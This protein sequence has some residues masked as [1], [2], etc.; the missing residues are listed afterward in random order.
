MV[1]SGWEGTLALS[2]ALP[3]QWGHVR[4]LS[5]H[6]VY[7]P[8][9]C[10]LV[11]QSSCMCREIPAPTELSYGETPASPE[12]MQ[13][14]HPSRC[15]VCPT[16]VPSA[17]DVMPAG[18]GNPA[19]LL[20]SPPSLAGALG[21]PHTEPTPDA[22]PL[23]RGVAGTEGYLSLPVPGCWPIDGGGVSRLGT[24]PGSSVPAD[25][26]GDLG[27]PGSTLPAAG[28]PLGPAPPACSSPGH[29]KE[30]LWERVSGFYCPGSGCWHGAAGKGSGRTQG[31][32]WPS[33]VL[34]SRGDEDA[35][36]FSGWVT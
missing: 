31:Q 7:K 28:N 19:R 22:E 26:P 18:G 4:V 12:A 3:P 16:A 30:L 9:R 23:R 25:S 14:A 10:C 32:L 34:C 27:F 33:A 1:G 8:Q 36:P 29:G 17:R 20:C 24:G 35:V 15:P 5:F 11:Q 21:H 6:C 2:P 13:P